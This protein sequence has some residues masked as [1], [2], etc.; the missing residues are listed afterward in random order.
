MGRCGAG[1]GLTILSVCSLCLV[2]VLGW[3]AVLEAVGLWSWVGDEGFPAIGLVFSF[4]SEYCSRRLRFS[5]PLVQRIL[6]AR[7]M[8]LLGWFDRGSLVGDESR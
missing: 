4:A 3:W 7:N 6:F 5:H 1:L 8:L 2:V